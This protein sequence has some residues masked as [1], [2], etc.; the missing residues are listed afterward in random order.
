MC[1]VGLHL[2]LSWQVCKCKANHYGDPYVRCEVNPCQ[3]AGCGHN[4]ECHIQ[5][6][7]IGILYFIFCTFNCRRLNYFFRAPWS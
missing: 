4:A 6:N 2:F 5:G 1:V 3:E 7:Q